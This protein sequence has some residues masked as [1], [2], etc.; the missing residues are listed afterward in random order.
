MPPRV[1]LTRR[2]VTPVVNE[3]ERLFALEVFEPDRAI[4]RTELLAAVAG[5]EGLLTMLTE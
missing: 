5:S 4:S 2:L 3:L 1:Y